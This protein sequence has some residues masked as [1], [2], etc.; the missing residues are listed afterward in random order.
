MRACRLIR[1]DLVELDVIV[2]RRFTERKML[3]RQAGDERLCMARGKGGRGFK[4]MKHMCKETKFRIL[5]TCHY[6]D[7]N[8]L[9]LLGVGAR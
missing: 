1:E 8:G 7:V 5:V 9:K 6:Q 4:S 3:G 2:K